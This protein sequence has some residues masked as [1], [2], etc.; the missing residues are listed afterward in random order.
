MFTRRTFLA[1]SAA[2]VAI[3]ASA[4]LGLAACGGDA[5][6]AASGG[7]TKLK[8]AVAPIQFETAYIAQQQGFFAKQGLDVEIVRGADPA[9]LLAQ[10]VSGDV[11]IAIGSW[12]NVATSA[13]KGVP[14]KVIGGNGIVDPKADNSGVLVSK[15][16]S[17]KSLKDLAGKTIGVVGVKS[18]GDIPVLQALEAAGVDVNS[19]KEVAIPYAGMQAALERN[20]VDAVVPADAFYHQMIS[21][22]YASISNPVREFQANMPVTV[23]TTTQQ[24]LAQNSAT[25]KKFDDAMTAAVSYFD[26]PANLEAVRKVNADVNQTDISKSPTALFKADVAFNV[27][28]AQDG[29]D[30]MNHFGL[31][32]KAVSVKDILWDQAPQRAAA[33][34]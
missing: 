21:A 6:S 2:V 32:T 12:I 26:D 15:G 3:A 19:V 7:T 23:W 25:A 11:N 33:G 24:W 20:T 28:E 8:I 14:V 13:A 9:A 5:Q 30:A 31:L 27:K 29:V 16:S 17:V 22:G 18:G 10:V 1:R 4:S 34:K